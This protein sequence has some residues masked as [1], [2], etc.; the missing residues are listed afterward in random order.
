MTLYNWLHALLEV[1]LEMEGSLNHISWTTTLSL[2]YH[3]WRTV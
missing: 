3:L 2:E 1:E